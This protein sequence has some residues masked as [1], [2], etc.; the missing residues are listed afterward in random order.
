MLNCDHKCCRDCVSK[1]FT[2]I[3]KDRNISEAT[4]PFC[5]EPKTLADDDDLAANYFAKLDVL[6]KP[7]IEQEVHDLF[8]RKLRDRTLMKDPNFKW[9]YKCSSGFI[10]DPKNKKLVCPDCRAMSCAKCL[11]PVNWGHLLAFTFILIFSFSLVGNHPW[12][13]VLWRLCSLERSQWSWQPSQ[14]SWKTLARAWYSVSQLQ[15]PIRSYQRGL[16]AFHLHPM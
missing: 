13:L 7:L 1:H 16:H 11:L 3:I 14:R 8:Q 9:C 2:I 15:I 5:L 6:L 4:C 10:A 12:G